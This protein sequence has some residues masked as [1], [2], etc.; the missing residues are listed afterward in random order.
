MTGIAKFVVGTQTAQFALDFLILM[1]NVADAQEN[2]FLL[3]K[4]KAGLIEVGMTIDAAQAKYGREATKLVAHYPEGMF[5]P[6]LEVYLPGQTST[7]APALLL[8]I[9]LENEWIVDGIGVN[10]AR[11]RTRE[12]I[13]VGSTLG[14]V[15]RAYR[16]KNIAFGEGPLYAN[17]EELNMS[18]ELDF[19]DP[20]PEWYRSRNQRLIPD[21]AKV[22]A[23]GLYR[24][25]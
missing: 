7:T 4:G 3:A 14:E 10:D 24:A 8:G 12:G 19:T 1:A 9:D 6:L 13:G 11:F 25:R 18:F 15:R 20:S 5:T 21:R 16:I 23:V 22:T 2:A 17:V